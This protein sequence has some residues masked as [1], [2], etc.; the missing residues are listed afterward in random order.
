MPSIDQGVGPVTVVA[1]PQAGTIPAALFVETDRRPVVAA[2]LKVDGA[3]AQPHQVLETLV[4]EPATEA[5]AAMVGSHC[6]PKELALVHRAA[7]ECVSHD[8][9]FRGLGDQKQ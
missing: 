6:Q 5:T 4:L 2:H 1:A 7:E 3:H 9:S 8:A